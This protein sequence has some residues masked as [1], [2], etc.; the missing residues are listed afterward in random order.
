MQ[1]KYPPKN[2]PIVRAG[3]QLFAHQCKSDIVKF[4]VAKATDQT[5]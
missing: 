3:S 5:G 1:S 4:A 2:L